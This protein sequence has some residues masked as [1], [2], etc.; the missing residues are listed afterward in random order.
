MR[1]GEILGLCWTDV[2][3]DENEI[4]VRHALQRVAGKPKL[5]PTKTARSRR[6]ISLPTSARVQLESLRIGCDLDQGP[7]DPDWEEV[8]LVFRNA[9][10]LPL[11]GTNVTRQFQRALAA[12]G[13]PRMRFHDLRHACAS[14]LLAQGASMRLIM[15]QLGH[16]QIGLT[17]NTY[18]HVMRDARQEAARLMDSVL[19]PGAG[20][21]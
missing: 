12:N 5:V 15:E 16:S 2:N 18:S 21:V 14:F 4:F 10:G 19:D 3:L 7:G 20:A 17:M 13:L 1:Q 6:F 9:R 11:D 8:G